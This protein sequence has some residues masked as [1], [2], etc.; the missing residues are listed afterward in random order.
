MLIFIAFIGAI[1]ILMFLNTIA[2]IVHKPKKYI[3]PAIIT[4]ILGAL[5]ISFILLALK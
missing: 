2:Y 5:L 1:F 4:A 3:P